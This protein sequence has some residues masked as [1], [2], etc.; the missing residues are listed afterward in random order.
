MPSADEMG[1]DIGVNACDLGVL[2][3]KEE[4]KSSSFP[5][6]ERC[7][8]TA[9]PLKLKLSAPAVFSLSSISSSNERGEQGEEKP[10][11]AEWASPAPTAGER[12]V[13]HGNIGSNMDNAGGSMFPFNSTPAVSHLVSNVDG[14]ACIAS[15]IVQEDQYHNSCQKSVRPIAN[16]IE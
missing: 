6:P 14:D 16:P 11:E 10:G 9:M 8:S 5:P 12:S 2:G 1:V 4:K 15:A 3:P 13:P 7:L